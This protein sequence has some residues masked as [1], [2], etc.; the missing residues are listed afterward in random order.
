[1]ALKDGTLSYTMQFKTYTDTTIVSDYLDNN[2]FVDR[3]D[4]DTLK[5]RRIKARQEASVVKDVAEVNRHCDSH[6]SVSFDWSALPTEWSSSQDELR[7]KPERYCSRVLG[8]IRSMCMG[9][10]ARGE[11]SRRINSIVCG[12][13]ARRSMDLKDGT[14]HYRISPKSDDD[15]EFVQT[16]LRQNL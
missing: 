6:I 16:Y 14:L 1:V 2:L 13:G 9:D 4:G 11:I 5:V 3:P 12:F 7:W 15:Y 10:A 8:A